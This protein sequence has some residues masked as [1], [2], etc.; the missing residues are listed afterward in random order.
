MWYMQ[1]TKIKCSTE[2]RGGR[3]FLLSLT[4]LFDTHPAFYLSKK[5]YF[6]CTVRA[7]ELNDQGSTLSWHVLQ[8]YNMS[9][10]NATW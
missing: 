1:R 9:Y 8:Q 6:A 10:S 5:I 4:A 3:W 7:M 2:P